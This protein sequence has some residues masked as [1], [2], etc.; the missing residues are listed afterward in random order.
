MRWAWLAFAL[1]CA[2]P[3]ESLDQLHQREQAEMAERKRA[4]DARKPPPAEDAAPRAAPPSTVA[5]KAFATSYQRR[6]FG[7]GI[8]ATV[9]ATGDNATT[10]SV[11]YTLCSQTFVTRR[12]IGSPDAVEAQR[13]GFTRVACDGAMAEF[14]QDL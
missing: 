8:D 5:R 12:F 7:Q 14:W 9:A 3:E 4:A 10:L 11:S 1:S 2:K 13:L 6:L